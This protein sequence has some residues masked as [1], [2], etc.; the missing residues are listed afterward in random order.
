MAIRFGFE[1]ATS[2][3][4]LLKAGA[5]KSAA[6]AAS[7]GAISQA[8]DEA[9]GLI[10]AATRKDWTDGYESLSSGAK[11]LLQ[12]G[13]TA[14]AAAKLIQF[15]MS[16]YSTIEEAQTMLDFL[17]NETNRAISILKDKK[18]EKFIEDA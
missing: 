15:D 14:A 7:G 12:D 3:A 2:S 5:N 11:W 10:N 9:M 16:G 13:V 18:T 1:M 6:I 17:N 8:H 4:I